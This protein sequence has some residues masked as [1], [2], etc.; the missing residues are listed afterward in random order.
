MM[1]ESIAL[2]LAHAHMQDKNIHTFRQ[3][4]I[5]LSIV[6]HSSEA[7]NTESGTASERQESMVNHLFD[8]ENDFDAY[9]LNKTEKM[10]KYKND[11]PELST[12]AHPKMPIN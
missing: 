3:E 6:T 11:G 10:L 7:L 2:P 1:T 4:Y 12:H 9:D 8:L 5:P